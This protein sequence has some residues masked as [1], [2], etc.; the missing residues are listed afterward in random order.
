MSE[1]SPKNARFWVTLGTSA[2]IRFAP[3]GKRVAVGPGQ[4]PTRPVEHSARHEWPKPGRADWPSENNRIGTYWTGG[5]SAADTPSQ[6]RLSFLTRVLGLGIGS[7]KVGRA[8]FFGSGGCGGRSRW[9][10][11]IKAT[12]EDGTN[13]RRL[14]EDSEDCTRSEPAIFAIFVQSSCTLSRSVRT[15]CMS[16]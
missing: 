5:Q 9:S 1:K 13:C 14:H 8:G 11:G 7:P 4:A 10:Q 15:G 2:R 3:A 6:I 16:G 12:D